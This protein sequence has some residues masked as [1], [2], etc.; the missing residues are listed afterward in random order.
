MKRESNLQTLSWEHHDG[1][2]LAFRI[3]RGLKNESAPE[4]IRSY[5]LR[6]WDEE[7]THHF[8]QEEEMLPV[9]L[10][11]SPEGSEL[12][13][14]L[15]REHRHFQDLITELRNRKTGLEDRL[16]EFGES[17]NIHIRFEERVLFPFVE[18]AAGKEELE[19]I[20]R[21]LHDQHRQ[22]KTCWQPAF[23][24]Q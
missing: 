6:I 23:W 2:V 17:L 22:P 1:L 7:L 8:W 19:K 3:D 16:R 20:G 13:D 9:I 4:L 18:N 5:V 21:F 24:R 15:I 11:R 12:H 10:K 14:R